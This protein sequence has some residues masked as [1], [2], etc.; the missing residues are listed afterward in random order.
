MKEGTSRQV[1]VHVKLQEKRKLILNHRADYV[2]LRIVDLGRHNWLLI[3]ER[4][5]PNFGS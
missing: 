3:V 1:G 5:S 4:L 2:C